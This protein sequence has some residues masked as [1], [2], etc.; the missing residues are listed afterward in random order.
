MQYKEYI[1]RRIDIFN[2]I[3]KQAKE[4][5][6]ALPRTSIK[7]STKHGVFEGISNETTPFMVSKAVNPGHQEFIVA[8]HN[9]ALW[10]AHR[11]IPA[12][13]H[14]EFLSFSDEEGK[15][16]FW[17][18]SAH[19]LGEASEK[20]YS[21]HLCL[22]PPT[23][24]GFFYE[25]QSEKTVT[26][27]DYQDLH[28]EMKA[29]VKERQPFVRLEMTKEQLLEMFSENPLKLE[30]INSK[31]QEKSTVYR[32]GPL[33]DFCLGPH[34]PSTS[35]IKSVEVTNHSSSFFLGD[36]SRPV[37]QRI[38]G[39]SFPSK[40]EMKEYMEQLEEA[41]KN[42]HRKIGSELDL[43]FF[44][45]VS[46]G[47][48]FFLP[49]GAFIY[50]ALVSL[51]REEYRKKGFK[52]VLT[53]NIYTNDLWKTSGHW[54][55]YKDD[56]F[57]FPADNTKM[58]LKPMN[59]PGHCVMFKHL[60]C[61]YRE[62]PLRLAD[63]GVLHRNEISGALT[64]LTRVRR[65][66]QDDAH[67]FV[68]GTHVS[69]EILSAL[70]FLKSIYTLLEF[71][72]TVSLS[73][74]PSNYMG[75]IEVWNRAEEQL[76]M[77]LDQSKI[78]WTLNEGD[79]AFYGPKI[80]ISVEDALKRKHQC[81]TIQLDFQMPK[82]F[83]L[84]FVN[85]EGKQEQPV[86][87]HRAILGSVERMTGILLEHFKGKLP[88]WLNPN[89]VIIIPLT[90]NET[91]YAK[92]IAEQL[93]EVEASV[94]L[95]ECTLNKKILNAQKQRFSFI[96]VVGP[97]DEKLQQVSIRNLEKEKPCS[98]LSMN[99]AVEAIIQTIRKREPSSSAA[100]KYIPSP[101]VSFS[102]ALIYL[103]KVLIDIKRKALSLL[104]IN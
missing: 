76:K 75:E 21:C 62:L 80:D 101:P 89:Q 72:Y 58:A 4:A 53:P 49:K 12:E 9:G 19:V 16:V 25:M 78:P 37:L 38:Y 15:K 48:C 87:I 24:S 40:A 86:M 65:F 94:D 50:N 98:V 85:H 42:N 93:S 32:C 68:A 41:K 99:S 7:I 3:E 56:M 47:S 104:R 91:K 97:K 22:G 30:L 61:S 34:V 54:D 52:E 39:V 83:N 64:G 28:K 35:Y 55:K 44:S 36:S 8:K 81:G 10:D 57:C 82:R 43:F 2:R 90:N 69:E 14:L 20:K 96:L 18:S 45:P 13:S 6:K 17:H 74:R 59:C 95:S 103:E 29:I 63:F 73:T 66:Q 11:P 23:D 31:V 100:T 46:P 67:I 60:S 88:P 92:S 1:Q 77:A 102:N 79:G 70:D 26:P 5:E 27:E 51:M 84:S 33:I 71:T